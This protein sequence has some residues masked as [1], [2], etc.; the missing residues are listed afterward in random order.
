MKHTPLQGI[1]TAALL[2]VLTL[3]GC[4]SVKSMAITALAPTFEDMNVAVNR[5]QDFEIVKQG[6]PSNIMLIEGLL[7]GAPDNRALLTLAA[8]TYC[9]YALGFV[10]DED[11]ERASYL[12]DRGKMHG[13]KVLM[14]NPAFQGAVAEGGDAL[15]EA[16][17]G[18]GGSDVASLFWTGN[19]WGSWINL[20]KDKVKALAEV[21]KV[22]LIM[23]RVLHLDETY[24]FGG[25][26]LFFAMMA[27]S[28]PRMFGGDPEKAQE[29]F[30]KTFAISEGKFL[31]PYVL[32]A[33]YYATFT[34]D[35][36]LYTT[37][38]QR[39]LD[40][41]SDIL[42]DQALANEIA[43]RKARRL[44]DDVGEYF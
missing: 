14:M 1:M 11:P 25:P 26:H 27:V 9:I 30:D 8:Q 35:E 20:N 33:R 16:L 23:K 15:S 31:L 10:E 28:K 32:Y 17:N 39:V 34:F 29:H 40:A 4:A 42:P 38:L 24:F 36:A 43:K 22:E 37:T 19:C 18:F 3:S 41:P 5:L 6:I 7:E 12:Y 44:L 2:A 21:P 13:L